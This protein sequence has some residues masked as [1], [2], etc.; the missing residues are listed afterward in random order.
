[1]STT[2]TGVMWQSASSGALVIGHPTSRRVA[3]FQQARARLSLPPARI[4]SYLDLLAGHTALGEH[5]RAGAVVRI[6]SPDKDFETQRALIAAGADVADEDE[7]DENEGNE[8]SGYERI[9]RRAAEQLM[10]ERGRILYP[11][12]WYLGFRAALQLIEAQLA[13]CPRHVPMNSPREIA[14]MFD[15]R[16][17][18]TLLEQG[19][20]S[21]PRGLGAVS[22]FDELVARMRAA[23]CARVF[24]KLAHG[25]SASGVVAYQT[26]G[27]RHQ[28][29]TTVEAVRQGGKLRLYN[30]RRIRVYRELGEVAELI[31]ALCRHRVHAE[32]W[33]PKAGFDG[34]T[35]DLR[36]VVIAG[37]VRHVVARL[38]RGPLTNLH[39]LNARSDAG[40]VIARMGP[41]AWAAARESCECAMRCFPQSLYA[42]LDLLI[43]PDYR[44]HAVLEVNAFGDLLPGALADGADTYTAELL[45]LWQPESESCLT[46][47]D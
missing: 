8:G 5:V 36:A 21:V 4:V 45:A 44:H 29:T 26:D 40:A 30:S 18:H 31:G 37:Q 19:G 2:A 27:R 6:E 1:M 7:A 35:F 12:Q 23:N 46:P 24:V 16:H 11:R 33:M 25:S 39:L 41:D 47:A 42:G 28:A 10:F 9:S 43:A 22:S 32:R 38:S 3:L 15:K 20:V 34:R 17:C 14:V 13:A